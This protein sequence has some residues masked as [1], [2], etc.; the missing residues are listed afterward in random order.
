MGGGEG[1]RGKARRKTVVA[2][3]LQ[4]AEATLTHRVSDLVLG[5]L[6]PQ[7]DAEH[8]SHVRSLM[9]SWGING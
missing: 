8:W 7:N 3:D 1:K 6:L 5:S 4:G 2:G 9:P